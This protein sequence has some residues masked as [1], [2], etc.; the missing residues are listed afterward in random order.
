MKIKFRTLLK[1]KKKNERKSITTKVCASFTLVARRIG[2]FGCMI[3]FRRFGFDIV[4]TPC[5]IKKFIDVFFS[6]IE[7]K[8]FCYTKRKMA[9]QAEKFGVI[10]FFLCL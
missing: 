1:K 6:K 10:V 5:Y 9:P 8:Q 4:K 2:P 7:E 3:F